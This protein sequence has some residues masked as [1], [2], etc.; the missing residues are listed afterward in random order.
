MPLAPPPAPTGG[1]LDDRLLP[2]RARRPEAVVRLLAGLA[3]IGLVLLTAGAG[4]ETTGGLD[5]DVAEGV[6][7]APRLLLGAAGSA[8]ALALV[9]LP[10]LFAVQRLAH[11]QERQ[12]LDGLVAALLTH[13]AGIALG[14]GG[15][16]V[17]PLGY[18]ACVV[19]FM[20]AGAMPERSWRPAMA[21]ALALYTPLP[22]AD[23]RSGVTAVALALL[24]GW[25]LAHG[26]ICVLGSPTDAPTVRQLFASLRR[27]GF[28]PASAHAVPEPARAR[29]RFL[30]RQRDGGPDLDVFVLDGTAR[31]FGLLGRAWRWLRLRIGPGDRDRRSP[32]V[33]ASYEALLAHAA[34]GTGART[35]RL[36]ATA[37]LGADAAIAVYEPLAGRRLDELADAE[38]TDALLAD[39][40]R[41]VGL[42]H[43][44]RTAHRALGASA[45]LVDG[46]GRVHVTE[47]AGGDIAASD[48]ALRIDVAQ[49]LTT[50]ALRVGPR[51]A[52]AAAL[53]SLGPHRTTSAVALLQPLALPR[54]TRRKLRRHERRTRADEA[55]A[56]ASPGGPAPEPAPTGVVPSEG[57]P[58]GSVPSRRAGSRTPRAGSAATTGLSTLRQ[59]QQ[60]PG[61]DKASQLS[62]IPRQPEHG[63]GTTPAPEPGDLLA[64]IR[65]EILSTTG[66]RAPVRP[67]RLERLRPRTLITVIGGAVAGYLLLL[68]LFGDNGNP[69]TA[70]ARAE[71]GWVGLAALL[72]ASRYGAATL[73]FIGFVPER[74]KVRRVALVQVAGSFVNLVSPS[75]VGGVAVNVRF[76]QR[77][78]IPLRQAMASVGV[79]QAVGLILHALLVLVFGLLVSTRYDSSLTLSPAVTTALLTVAVAALT[80]TAVPTIR[81]WLGARLQ[82]LLAGVLPRLLGL[83]RQPSKLAAGVTGQLFISLT[84]VACLYSC[85]RAFGEQPGFMEVAVAALVG[86]ALG[87]AVPTPGGVGGVEVA[88]AVALEQAAGMAEGSAI[89][90]VLLYRLLTFW[91]PVLPGW[92]AFAR[93]QRQRAI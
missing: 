67:V 8:G 62:Q 69:L 78:G 86:T 48:L 88:L 52:V 15:F 65:E 72:S 45:L 42:L 58:Y 59:T 12:V 39:A 91:L 2:A 46:A 21:V 51:R 64:E 76:L 79:A 35:R 30:V 9:V 22:L 56:G 92:L 17:A 20:T 38:V 31:A 50:T 13:G 87:S 77:S 26:T 84:S 24:T 37:D 93:L 29:H 71:P 34:A 6:D 63:D 82:P 16:S 4:L 10:V 32:R 53:A 23:G 73:G 1:P 74:L 25:T 43:R 44:R 49:L 83:L 11:R 3:L 66:L 75:G 28:A 54:A 60:V 40:W 70:I 36:L 33:R 14:H 68:Q 80:I 41:Q 90:P 5:A 61:P 19:A 27:V 81:R 55:G 7:G 89:A 57:V 47:L 18:A 85:A